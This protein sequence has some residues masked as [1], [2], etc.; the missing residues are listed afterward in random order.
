MNSRFN[1]DGGV[2]LPGYVVGRSAI[3]KMGLFMERGWIGTRW[4]VNLWTLHA[5]VIHM[6]R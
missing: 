6:Q 1:G 5:V 2:D 4:E 3:L